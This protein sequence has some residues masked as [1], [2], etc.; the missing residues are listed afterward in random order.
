MGLFAK[1]CEGIEE[2][3][4]LKL[5]AKVKALKQAGQNVIS[6]AAGEPHFEPPAFLY[7]A[8]KDALVMTYAKYTPVLGLLEARKAVC[9]WVN[10]TYRLSTDPSWFAFTNGAKGGIHMAFQVL[11]NPGDEVIFQSPYWVSYPAMVQISGGVSKIIETTAAGRFRITPEQL[12]KA[13]SSKT[14]IFLFNSPQNPTG[15]AY[16]QEEIDALADVLK[17]H[18]QVYI[19]SD[20]IYDHVLWDMS[21]RAHFAFSPGFDITR[22]IHVQGLSKSHGVTGWRV[23]YVCANPDVTGHINT[24]MGH[25]LGHI[26]GI[27]QHVLQV[28]YTQPFDFLASWVAYFHNNMFN[29]L[30]LLE[31]MGAKTVV[32]D[33]AFYIFPE[34]TGLYEPLSQKL[35]V[36]ITDDFSLCEHL[37]ERLHVG[38]V[39]GSEFGSPGYVRLTTAMSAEDFQE[40]LLRIKN[41]L[42]K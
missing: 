29:A 1:R 26:S 6:Y 8:V 19:L 40:G 28:A 38:L 7:N 10:R 22:L 18:P 20:D 25:A 42:G 3:A 27:S 35:G 23:G 21:K 31:S 13:I 41:A 12:E 34:I 36:K 9:A 4:T 11:L 15:V 5:T 33:G 37:L 2:S 39:P 32:P 14:K 24:L 16:T 30:P 17:K